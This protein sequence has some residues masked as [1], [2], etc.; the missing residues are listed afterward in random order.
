MLIFRLLFFF[1][2]ISFHSCDAF[3]NIACRMTYKLFFSR[4]FVPYN[5]ENGF[6]TVRRQFFSVL[7][8]ISFHILPMQMIFL[9]KKLPSILEYT[10]KVGKN[11]MLF[12]FFAG[13]WDEKVL[14]INWADLL[15]QQISKNSLSGMDFIYVLKWCRHFPGFWSLLILQVIYQIGINKK[16]CNFY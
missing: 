6:E 11:T 1:L 12:S 4:K 10:V 7:F 8:K 5:P 13:Q 15:R 14:V 2:L 3:N 16:L 9:N